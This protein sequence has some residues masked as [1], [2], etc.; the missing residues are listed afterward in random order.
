MV[1]LLEGYI[2]AW[3]RRDVEACAGIYAADARMDDSTFSQ[4]LH[5][6][7]AIEAY[8]AESFAAMPEN[9]T[10]EIHNVGVG[11][12]CIF[13]E[14]TISSIDEAGVAGG[15][16]GISAWDVEDGRVVWDRSYWIETDGR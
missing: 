12:K 3:R 2:A 5:G 11:E 4:P 1:R 8:F 10:R 7:R 13:F 9:T 6:S 15:S 14:W 16:K